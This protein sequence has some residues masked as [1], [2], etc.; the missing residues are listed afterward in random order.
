M[1]QKW[2]KRLFDIVTSV[3]G[4]VI[5]SP[6]LLLTASIIVVFM[7]RPVIFTQKRPGKDEKIFKLYKFRT[8]TQVK[9]SMD[10]LESDASR[11]TKIGLF[12]RK[13]SIDELP[14]LW[15][16]LKG[17]MSVVGPRPLLVEYLPL[18]SDEQKQ[19]HQVRP[20][21]T[22]LAQTK[23]RNAITWNEKFNYDIQYVNN[24]SFKKDIQILFNTVIKVLKKEGISSDGSVTSEKFKGNS[25]E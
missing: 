23:G 10:A 17:D 14:E 6:I 18:Y 7:G 19:R 3:I 16:I 24:I 12:L 15:N 21:L 25:N 4:I 13:T 11:L 22:G 1:Y 2:G 5:L 20:G 9:S 8:M